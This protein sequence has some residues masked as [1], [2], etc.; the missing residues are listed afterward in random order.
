MNA[1]HRRT[2]VSIDALHI[3]TI[4]GHLE[5]EVRELIASDDSTDLDEMADV[6]AIAFHYCQRRGWSERQVG[7]AV[8]GKLK[9]RLR[10]APRKFRRM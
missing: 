7:R 10:L 1:V 3:D 9:K 4:L 5:D 6:L 2:G 8:I